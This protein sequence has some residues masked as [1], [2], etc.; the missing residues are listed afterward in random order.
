MS[1]NKRANSNHRR[2]KRLVQNDPHC[3]WCNK[4]VFQN[5][6]KGKQFHNTATLDHVYQRQQLGERIISGNPAVLSCYQCNQERNDALHL[7]NINH[8]KEYNKWIFVTRVK[9]LD[10]LKLKL[11]MN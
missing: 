2:V 7:S 8:W 6:K 4:E 5:S 10:N 11:I 1:R 3:Y 9:L